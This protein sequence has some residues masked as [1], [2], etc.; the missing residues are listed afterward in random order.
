MKRI[1][2]IIVM[3][4]AFQLGCSSPSVV[5]DQA[6]PYTV[7]GEDDFSFPGRTRIQFNIVSPSS[8]TFQQYAHTAMKA[9]IDMQK[10]T[11]SQV[12]YVFLES[13]PILHG[14][15]YAYA[16]ARYARD[17]GGN[18]GDQG[19]TWEVEAVKKPYSVQEIEIAELWWSNRDKFQKDGFTDEPK[20]KKFIANNMKIKVEEVSLPWPNRSAYEPIIKG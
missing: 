19:W 17:G 4:A 16:I 5:T 2:G 13:S 15:G 1:V 9:A 7:V 3:L 14:K 10:E 6:Q 12:V 18:S 8:E 20:L 11:Y